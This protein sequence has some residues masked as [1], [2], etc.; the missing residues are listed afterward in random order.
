MEN[1][2]MKQWNAGGSGSDGRYYLG[3]VCVVMN[4]KNQKKKRKGKQKKE[5]R[6][7]TLQIHIHAPMHVSECTH[8]KYATG[9]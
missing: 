1:L 4:Y 2:G 7:E 6:K 3:L 9:G 8:E 5:K